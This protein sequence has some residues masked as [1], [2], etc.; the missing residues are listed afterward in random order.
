MLQMVFRKWWLILLQG[1]L[2]IVLSYFIFDNP[3][4]VLAGISLWFGIVVILIGLTGIV[5]WMITPA[6]DRETVSLIWSLATALL[7]LLMLMN[8][9]ATMKTLTIIFGIWMLVT[10]YHLLTTGWQLR[11]DGWLGWLLVIVGI[12]SAIAGIMMITNIGA[13]AIGISTLLGFQVLLAGIAMVLFA[14]VKKAIVNK[15]GGRIEEL[16]TRTGS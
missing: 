9:F 14:F 16:K 6:A 12:L 5:V 2:M 3:V 8:M 13:G 10:A 15:I 11:Q 7:G 4:A 1:I